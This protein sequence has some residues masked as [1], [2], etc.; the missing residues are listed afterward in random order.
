MNRLPLIALLCAFQ[1]IL[2]SLHSSSRSSWI[3]GESV[4]ARSARVFPEHTQAPETSVANTDEPRRQIRSE[5]NNLRDAYIRTRSKDIFVWNL[6][7]YKITNNENPAIQSEIQ[8]FVRDI[9]QHKEFAFLLE[10]ESQQQSIIFRFLIAKTHNLLPE[11]D[12]KADTL[13]SVAQS[14]LFA[15]IRIAAIDTLMS[16]DGLSENEKDRAKYALCDLLNVDN[17]CAVRQHAGMALGSVGDIDVLEALR[18]ALADECVEVQT[19]ADKT[20]RSILAKQKA[21][22]NSPVPVA[23]SFKR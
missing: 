3:S 18:K 20:I 4:N 16:F 13:I 21:S 23:P 17:S 5:L 9:E 11:T 1:L 19:A 6:E 2:P 14:Q 15:G 7:T 8:E 12:V 10:D 22:K